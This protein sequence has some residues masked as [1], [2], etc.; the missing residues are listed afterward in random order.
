GEEL[1]AR[2]DLFSFGVVLYEMATGTLPFKGNTSA[3]VFNAILSQVPIS[4]LRLNP[5]LPPTL[6]EII[7]KAL[8]KDRELRYQRA[9]DLRADLKRLKRDT[10]SGTAVA[11]KPALLVSEPSLRATSRLL[12]HRRV[13]GLA[14]AFLIVVVIVLFAWLRSPR[15]PPKV[16]AYTQITSDGRQKGSLVTDGSRIYFNDFAGGQAFIN[17][18]SAMGGET[19]TIPVS[20][21]SAN[22][23]DISPNGSE[24]LVVTSSNWLTPG[25]LWVLPIPGGT[26]RR[27]GEVLAFDAAWSPDG[28]QITYATGSDLYLCKSNGSESHKL[29]TVDGLLGRPRL[30]PDGSRLRFT[31]YERKKNSF[32]LWE[33]TRDGTQ[34]HRLLPGWNEPPAECCGKWTAD[35]N[36][37]VFQSTRETPFGKTSLWALREKAG[38]LQSGS[39]EPIQL[40]VGPL[41]FFEP[42][43]SKDG[44]RLLAIGQ[45]LR[46]E[47]VRYDGKTKQF[48]SY[49]S[50]I[51]AMQLDFSRDGKWVCY[52]TYPEWSLWRSNLDSSQRLQLTFPPVHA[53]LPRWSPDGKKIAFTNVQIGKPWKLYLISTEG[54]IPQQLIP[55]E[56]SEHDPNWTP[57][58]NAII[59][60]L[61]GPGDRQSGATMIQQLDLKTSHITKL[62]GSEGLWGPT[63]SPNGRHICAE[64][65]TGESKLVLFDSVTQ[66]WVEKSKV[67]PTWWGA[68]SRGG[69][70]FYVIDSTPGGERTL[71]RARVDDF[72]F[73]EVVSFRD[74]RLAGPWMGLS[75]DD[76]PLLLRDVGTQ[77]IYALDWEAP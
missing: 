65:A 12:K 76:S 49:L 71:S 35:G 16:L 45:Q 69:D 33:V 52:V 2:T 24:L 62:P 31:V 75:P 19:V 74:L 5:E 3:V 51:S 56:G 27:V 34:L 66:K 37:Y 39:Q 1:D 6:E 68:W 41:N 23:A 18:V 11:G 57:D 54:S 40:T 48:V 17:Q 13:V 58:G 22:I 28:Q 38:F 15:P 63:L 30:S 7:N 10:D 43:P 61:G 25:P 29:V 20:L 4:P 67:S 77:D 8:E 21:Q 36:Y 59:F 47:L 50:G 64:T 9:S 73:E 26:P 32:S 60:G 53:L 55:G 44:K 14:V 70:T 72:K 42:V 46:G